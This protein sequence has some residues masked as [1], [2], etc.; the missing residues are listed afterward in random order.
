MKR[1]ILLSV[2]AASTVLILSSCETAKVGGGG[3]SAAISAATVAARAANAT[4]PAPLDTG[5]PRTP[6][7]EE[8]DNDAAA[9][10]AVF[11]GTG[12][13]VKRPRSIAEAETT[14]AGDITLNFANADI[15]EVVRTI[16]GDILKLNYVIDSK[17]KGT[18]TVQTSRPL[19]REALLP[20]LESIFHVNGAT[21]VRS[22]GLYKIVP[23]TEAARQTESLGIG[24]RRPKKARGFGI[25]IVPLQYISA[26]E[27]AKI[28]DPLAQKGSIL[29]V[30]TARNLLILAASRPDLQTLLETVEIFDVD[31]LAGTSF[32]LFPLDYADAK[33][34]TEELEKVLGDGGDERLAGLVR[35]VPIERLNAI[36]VISPRQEFLSRAETW[37]ERLDRGG[38][39]GGRRLFVY[40]V[41][42]GKAADL[43]A[44]LGQIFG[45]EDAPAPAPGQVAPNLR[46]REVSAAPA[47]P[48]VGAQTQRQTAGAAAPAAAR[49]ASGAVTGRESSPPRSV[50]FA[51][52]GNIRVIADEANNALVILSSAADY[53]MVSDALKKLDVVPLQVLIEATI[54]EV[55]LN[56]D[57]R[58]GLQWFFKKN[59]SEFTLSSVATG[60]VAGI[61][62]G[63]SYLFAGGDVR[64]VL[65][66]LSEITDLNII[67]SPQLMVLGNQTA[68]LQVGDQVP[69]ATQSAVS[70]TDPAAPIVNNVEFRDTGVILRVTPR[71]NKG[72]L[73]IMDIEQEVSSVT[74][75]T[76]STI[77]SPTIIQ[78]K[79]KSSVAVQSGET[80][81]LG[82]LIQETKDFKKSGIP[83]LSDIP[84]IGA[85]FGT[86]NEIEKRTELLVLI[87][88]RVVRD[89]TEARRVTEELRRRLSKV[90]KLSRIVAPPLPVPK[91]ARTRPPEEQAEPAPATDKKPAE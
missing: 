66:A 47:R 55:T 35:F 48:P 84:I 71:V 52:E 62:P 75:T 45:A 14:P 39:E 5:G 86:T 36:L 68:V 41:Q 70:V 76:T 25:Q 4:G 57:L 65:N 90:G 59:S 77:D 1:L 44:I 85:L 33:T 30:D 15:R 17:V 73:V 49:P 53:R 26:A 78:R 38:G 61:F 74:A 50:E 29:R 8:G 67:S 54:A 9:K 79:I 64:V 37:I 83:F 20:T 40:S 32:G 18:I 19:S 72:G 10:S 22:G 2:A 82:G 6:V 89:Q 56:D 31:W 69:I 51:G 7:A 3:K 11:P 12:T 28:I 24:L 91:P 81:A 42:N 46:P 63:F 13:F 88:P 16:L 27:M 21:M 58:F 87:T 60:T 23:L 43:A 34:V 80:V